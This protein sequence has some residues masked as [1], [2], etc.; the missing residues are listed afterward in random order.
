M[1]LNIHLHMYLES[2]LGKTHCM[3]VQKSRCMQTN[4]VLD[5]STAEKYLHIYIYISYMYIYANTSVLHLNTCDICQKNV[6]HSIPSMVIIAVSRHAVIVAEKLPTKLREQR[7][8]FPHARAH[9]ACNRNSSHAT[10][11]AF[12]YE[13]VQKKCLSKAKRNKKHV[14]NVDWKCP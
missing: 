7:R 14:Q 8:G 1:L 2:P 6:T 12:Q 4:R 10:H 5:I 3:H 13:F 11:C 9:V